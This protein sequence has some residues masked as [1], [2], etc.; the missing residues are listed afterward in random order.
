MIAEVLLV[1]AATSGAGPIELN[2]R[3]YYPDAAA[4]YSHEA[5][6]VSCNSLVIYREESAFD[7]KQRSWGSML[8]FVGEISGDRMKVTRVYPRHRDSAEA[9]GTCDILYRDGSISGVSCLAR[10]GSKT[11][12][13][14][15]VRSRL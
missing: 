12:V 4:Q 6:F 8:R 5:A 10:A 9:A 15:F 1:L 3:C 11:Y 7:F 14:N 13:A 2:G